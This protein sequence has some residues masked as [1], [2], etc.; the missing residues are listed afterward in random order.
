MC[1]VKVLVWTSAT[2]HTR[3]G[4]VRQVQMLQLPP[5]AWIGL[6]QGDHA[7]EMIV[8]CSEACRAKLLSA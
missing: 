6:V 2:P 8:V 5:G 1:G 7:Q 3:R 4:L